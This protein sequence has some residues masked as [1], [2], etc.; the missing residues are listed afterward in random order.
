MRRPLIQLVDLSH[1][2]PVPFIV[3]KIREAPLVKHHARRTRLFYIVNTSDRVLINILRD[4]AAEKPRDI[5]EVFVS[6]PVN[7]LFG[8]AALYSGQ[9]SLVGAELGQIVGVCGLVVN[10]VQRFRRCDTLTSKT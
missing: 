8:P 7:T 5:N 3:V 1:Q 10:E 9:Q 6:H 2:I 4:C